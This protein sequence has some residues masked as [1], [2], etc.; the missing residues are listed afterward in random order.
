MHELSKQAE[1]LDG[2]EQRITDEIAFLNSLTGDIIGGWTVIS[3]YLFSPSPSTF[4]QL[5]NYAKLG[6]N[7]ATRLER[8]FPDNPE[9]AQIAHSAQQMINDEYKEIQEVM[10]S[11]DS[12]DSDSILHF[13]DSIKK[14]RHGVQRMA[15]QYNAVMNEL[16]NQRK[17]LTHTRQ[18]EKRNREQIDFQVFVFV[19][20][21]VV[22]A[23][24]L[25]V[26]FL[27]DIT[28]RLAVLVK[29]AETIPKGQAMTLKV[30]GSDELAYL[31]Q[32]MH[33]VSAELS[34]A[35]QYRSTVMTMLAHDLRSPL[36]AAQ[37]TLK[38]VLAQSTLSEKQEETRLK[39]AS[40]NISRVISLVEDLLTIDK[41][42]AG[43]LEL[44]RELIDAKPF[45][46][47]AFEAVEAL[48]NA[49]EVVLKNNVDPLVIDA[50]R[51]R[52]MQ[53]MQ[54]LLSNAIKH[55]PKQGT[56]TVTSE[57]QPGQVALRIAD[58]GP[59]ISPAD[60]GKL[61]DKFYQA[62]TAQGGFGLG[63]AITKMIV[64]AHGGSCGAQA[65]SDRGS[66]FWFSLPADLRA[67]D[68]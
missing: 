56:I 31:D 55:S 6:N 57:Q 64:V 66:T 1:Q 58:E 8:T 20:L 65:N 48:A 30:S 28:N 25:L 61:F 13:K 15:V 18:L 5:S 38:S 22:I 45:V 51:L 4:E 14:I 63:L 41:L 43:K 53:V 17:N 10:A 37:L 9:A 35:A 50:D 29:N 2:E 62:D 40:Q 46:D 49:Q 3:D 27:Q 42:E 7:A 19:I 47:D 12:A 11:K 39:G 16:D 26:A 44:Q 34:V 54:N 32:V 24:V 21:D 52:M 67:E 60:S 68:E 23:L 33:E 36:S 59:G